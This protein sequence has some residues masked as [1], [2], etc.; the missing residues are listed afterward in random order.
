MLSFREGKGVRQARVPL[1]LGVHLVAAHYGTTPERV[2]ETWPADD[3]L[4]ALAMLGVT[5]VIL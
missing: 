4:D 1:R 5:G 2:R 3:Y